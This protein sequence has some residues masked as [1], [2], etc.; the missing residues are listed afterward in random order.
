MSSGA[1]VVCGFCWRGFCHAFI[2]D[3]VSLR[4]VNTNEKKTCCS[5]V[6]CNSRVYAIYSLAC[7]LHKSHSAQAHL[8]EVNVMV[9]R[10]LCIRTLALA[11][12]CSLVHEADLQVHT[13]STKKYMLGKQS[14]LNI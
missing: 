8:W 6:D 12:T 2:M 5:A 3:T 7:L 1:F 9:L 13:Y 11:V 10:A 4:F 14:F